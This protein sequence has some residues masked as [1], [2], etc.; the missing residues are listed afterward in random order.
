MS[1]QNSFVNCNDQ[2]IYNEISG[3]FEPLNL[4]R[5]TGKVSDNYISYYEYKNNEKPL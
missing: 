2:L 5:K 1:D 4:G 3:E